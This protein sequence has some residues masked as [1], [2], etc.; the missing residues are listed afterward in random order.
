MVF[1]RDIG[2]CTNKEKQSHFF[3]RIVDS[4]AQLNTVKH[5]K[6]VQL[7]FFLRHKFLVHFVCAYKMLMSRVK[8]SLGLVDLTGIG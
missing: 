4:L 7:L 5:N 2:M 8:T 3:F 1:T 6:N